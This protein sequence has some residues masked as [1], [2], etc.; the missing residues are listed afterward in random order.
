MS[1]I[2]TNNT[3]REILDYIWLP[4]SISPYERRYLRKMNRRGLLFFIHQIPL[5]MLVAWIHGTGVENAFLLCAAVLIGP[6]LAYFTFKNPRHVSMLYGF[7]AMCF[8]GVLVHLGQG[9]M[10]IEMHFYFFILIAILTIY[11]N[12]LVILIAATTVAAHHLLLYFLLPESVF[13]YEAPILVVFVHA[14]FVVLE[15]IAAIVLSRSFFDN[16][17]GL[18][19]IVLQRTNQLD[20]R[21]R[22]MR[23]VLDNVAQGLMTISTSGEI[24][25]EHS[26][27]LTNWFGEIDSESNL[28]ELFERHDATAS[29]WLDMGL[30][31]VRDGFMPLELCI[32]QLPNTLRIDR[33]VLRIDYSPIFH[34]AMISRLL[35]TFTDCTIEL[36]QKKLEQE[37]KELVALINKAHEDRVAFLGFMREARNIVHELGSVELHQAELD[38]KRHIHTLKGNAGFFGLQTL[39]ELC[40]EL[41][42]CLDRLELQ[43]ADDILEQLLM[44]WSKI[45]SMLHDFV[46]SQASSVKLDHVKL[47]VFLEA[48]ERGTSRSSLIKQVKS[49]RYE[50]LE[51]RLMSLGQQA[52]KIAID[53]DKPA[54]NIVIDS[55]EIYLSPERWSGFWNA[56][57]HMLRNAVDHGIESP[58]EREALGKNPV[59]K[60]SFMSFCIEERFVLEFA[61]DGHGIDWERLRKKSEACGYEVGDCEKDRIKLLFLEGVSTRE[62]VTPISGRGVGMAAVYEECKQLGGELYVDSA[63]NLGTSFRFVFPEDVLDL[64]DPILESIGLAEESEPWVSNGNSETRI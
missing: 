17:V 4:R 28:V 43:R 49:W 34:G 62:E 6:L 33:R 23:L 47:N 51:A 38:I 10:Q 30:E 36:E 22:D 53:I 18:E 29:M 20:E 5:F 32:D 60:L 21:N 64:R 19:K 39:A 26:T 54:V 55:E 42:S 63:P 7:A 56:F 8:G 35:V 27:V 48:L 11:A 31:A 24:S 41:E 57:T 9:P 16:V 59:G 12:P 45:D 46:D 14:L 50:S 61:D 44:R 25:S 37:Q 2:R 58:E 13:N 52:R 40:H 3:M 1:D 15:S